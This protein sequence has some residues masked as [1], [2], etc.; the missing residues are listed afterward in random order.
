MYHLICELNFSA[1]MQRKQ[2]NVIV[3]NA[4]RLE[5]G[6]W[7]LTAAS[8]T[9]VVGQYSAM[10]IDYLVSRGLQLEKLHLIG[11][12]LGAQMAGVAGFNVRS[13]KIARITGTSLKFS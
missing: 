12:S 2:H 11:L 5:A 13:G 6:P 4:Q 9:R 7:Y 3:L 10:F 1:Y 8:N